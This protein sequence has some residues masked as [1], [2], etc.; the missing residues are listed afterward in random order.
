MYNP[1]ILFVL[2]SSCRADPC[3]HFSTENINPPYKIKIEATTPKGIKVDLSGQ[4][5]SL[6]LID[7]V[8]DSVEQC[9]NDIFPDKLPPSITGSG[10]CNDWSQESIGNYKHYIDRGCITI[11]IPNT[12]LLSNDGT[13]MVLD[14]DADE[15]LCAQKPNY[16]KGQG[17]HWRAGLQENNTIVA[18]PDLYMLPDPI[19]R[20]MT[21]CYNA[22]VGDLAK[23]A[24]P[25]TV[26]LT[27]EWA[28]E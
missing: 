14:R 15:Y 23:C 21:S 18:L 26:P 25:R 7:R 10:S 19:V 2:I 3:D 16:I 24:M 27:G 28:G 12:W 9:M 4:N 11:K 6:E 1:L 17:C 5:V 8:V 13:Q 22:W 20:Y